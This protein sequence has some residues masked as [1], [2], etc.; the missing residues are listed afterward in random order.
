[1]QL[2]K[3]LSALLLG[4]IAL[5]TAQHA[6]AQDTAYRHAFRIYEDNDM[7]QPFG[8]MSDEGYT[9]GTRLDYFYTKR[10]D[11]RFFLD[12]WLPKAGKD[13]INTYGISITQTMY[14]PEDPKEEPDVRDWPYTGALYLSHTLH[15][16]N[17]AKGY[18]LQTELIGGVMGQASGAQQVQDGIHSLI[19]SGEFKGWDKQYPTDV[20]LNLNFAVEKHLWHYRQ[21]LDVT[22]GAQVMAGTMTDGASIYSLIRIGK[23]LPY[24]DGLLQQFTRPFRMRNKLQLYLFARPALEWVA[25]NAVLEGGVFSGKSGYYRDNGPD[26]GANHKISRRLDLGLV[27]SYGS[28]S[29][30]FTQRI[31]QRLVD[32][33]PHQQVG[34]L[35]LYVAF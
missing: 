29:V 33:L 18:N 19:N 28:L 26:A 14:T 12:R 4:T 5:F 8:A 22:G 20:L 10:H 21:A 9:N 11:A 24:F 6:V 7:L 23:M 35:T 3:I 13:A 25:Y 34:N 27:M 2:T 15:S 32:G 17:P 1:M 31:M 16:S 30:S